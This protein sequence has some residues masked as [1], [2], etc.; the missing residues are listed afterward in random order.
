MSTQSRV[1]GVRAQGSQPRMLRLVALLLVG[2]ACL[3]SIP[4]VYG[5]DGQPPNS[6]WMRRG[7]AILADVAIV[8]V[9]RD[10]QPPVINGASPG[11]TGPPEVIPQTPRTR[12]LRAIGPLLV[13]LAA[14]L[15]LFLA[16][17]VSPCIRQVVSRRRTGGSDTFIGFMARDI[18]V[19][20]APLLSVLWFLILLIKGAFQRAHP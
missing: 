3:L 16:D 8:P 2:V 7:R 9:F 6:P 11:G 18:E 4:G 17:L 20:F 19:A 13:K 10:E 15:S 1:S 12:P 5:A 14:M